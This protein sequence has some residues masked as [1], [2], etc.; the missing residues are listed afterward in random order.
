MQDQEETLA[1]PA[2][3][4]WTKLR[5][6]LPLASL[7]LLGVIFFVEPTFAAGGTTMPFEGKIEAVM[8]SLCGPVARS[9]CAIGICAAGIMLIF[10][11]ELGQFFKTAAMTVAAGSIAI[12]A[13]NIVSFLKDGAMTTP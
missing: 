10:G 1:I 11:S 4:L 9:I 5:R 12:L 8:K 3:T 13:V 6:R 2:P 7:L